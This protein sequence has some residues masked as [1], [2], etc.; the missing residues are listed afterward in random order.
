[1]VKMP[2]NKTG[3]VQRLRLS[4]RPGRTLDVN[5]VALLLIDVLS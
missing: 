5:R 3:A 1:M 4:V 2:A